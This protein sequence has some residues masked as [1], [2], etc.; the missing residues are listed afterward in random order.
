M[1]G[2]QNSNLGMEPDISRPG[3]DYES[4]SPEGVPA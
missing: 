3:G 4:R 2:R 1:V